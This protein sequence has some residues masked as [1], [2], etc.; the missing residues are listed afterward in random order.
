M[1]S[2]YDIIKATSSSS[3]TTAV[4]DISNDIGRRI[5]ISNDDG[6]VSESNMSDGEGGKIHN[7]EKYI[8]CEQNLTY[9]VNKI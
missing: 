9:D 2:N 4:D 1:S 3:G 6:D 5:D 8:S 7:N